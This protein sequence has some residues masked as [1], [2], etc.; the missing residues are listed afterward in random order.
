MRTRRNQ[1][2]NN[3]KIKYISVLDKVYEVIS[4]QWLHSYLEARETDLSIDDVPE[5]EL[6]DISY[7]ED[8]RV[9]LV[10]RKG[11]AKII[12]MAEWLGQHSL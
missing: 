9:R 12:D 3:T 1:A 6:W 7:F 2:I 8:F 10:N 4:I 11:E 5:S